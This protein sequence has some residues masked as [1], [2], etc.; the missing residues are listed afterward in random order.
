MASLPA[1]LEAQVESDPPERW[2]IG[3]R[4]FSGVRVREVTPLSVFFMHDGGVASLPLESLPPEWQ[5]R[6]QY[7][8]E[9]A[10]AYRQRN[11][12][13]A[14]SAAERPD[15]RKTAASKRPLSRQAPASPLEYFG[16]P[17]EL[18]PEVDLRPQFIQL[19]LATRNQGRRPSCAVF[20]VVGALELQV[21][22]SLGRPV[23]LSEEYLIWATRQ[24]L[25]LKDAPPKAQEDGSGDEDAGFSLVEVVQALR[26]FGIPDREAMPYSLTRSEGQWPRP[27]AEAMEQA[28]SRRTINAWR[29]TGRS[30]AVAVDNL[31]HVLNLGQPAVIGVRWPPHRTLTR[32]ALL[33]Q[34]VPREDYAHAVTLVGYR[35]PP[36]Q[37][38]EMVFIFRNSWGR[39]WGAGGYGF[40]TR[41]YLERHLLDA[42]FL[43]LPATAN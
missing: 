16:R 6:F 1:L 13:R 5:A 26:A 15:P 41:R 40:M 3:D 7:D 20:A 31:V 42:I 24:S 39:Q 34:Q 30:P 19:E 12:V 35:C 29:I 32:T 23:A 33:S 25:G 27:P 17:A 37:P 8:A 28:A 22:R 21:A 10:E 2:E 18:R 36:D 14:T 43:E 4:V 38:Q 11:Q 9:A